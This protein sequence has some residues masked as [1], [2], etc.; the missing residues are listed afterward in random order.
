MTSIRRLV[1]LFTW[2]CWHRAARCLGFKKWQNPRLDNGQK[3]KLFVF[4]GVMSHQ[5]T[6]FDWASTSIKT[7]Q[8]IPLPAFGTFR[9]PFSSDKTIPCMIRHDS[10]ISVRLK[11][12]KPV[13]PPLTTRQT[14]LWFSIASHNREQWWAHLALCGLW[15]LFDEVLFYPWY[16][17]EGSK[18]SNSFYI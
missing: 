6:S 15:W 8:S 11:N 17:W 2:G 13:D 7:Q 5:C 4:W 9:P 3:P 16:H 14:C 12:W 18:A 10:T 1:K